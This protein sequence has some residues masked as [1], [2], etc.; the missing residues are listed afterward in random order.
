MKKC[1][2]EPCDECM[3]YRHFQ[4]TNKDTGVVEV[5]QA[6]GIEV[7]LTE[8]VRL[9]SAVDGNQTAANEARNAVWGLA[10]GMAAHGY[11]APLRALQ[12]KTGDRIMSALQ[13]EA[14][15]IEGEIVDQIEE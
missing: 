13:T 2:C 8:I 4:M 15:Q 11:S 10:A 5:K 3:W 7:I 1:P 12:T 6:C 9:I 14:E